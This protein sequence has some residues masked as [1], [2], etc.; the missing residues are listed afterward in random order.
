M[1]ILDMGPRIIEGLPNMIEFTVFAYDK[2]GVNLVLES[3]DQTERY[4][5][6]ETKPHV[7]QA[8]IENPAPNLL[9]SYE[10]E[11]QREYPDPYSHFQPF[12]VHGRSQVIDHSSY[13]WQ[14]SDWQG[15]NPEELIVME[16]H[17]ATFTE[18]GT[19]KA[20]AKKLDYLCH[21][22]VNALELMPVTPTP[23]RWNW[24]YDGTCLFSVN[25]NYGT[26]DDLKYL[27]DSCH[28][29]QMTVI[30]DVVYNHFGPEGTYL[31]SFGPYFTDKHHTPWGPAVNFDDNYCEYTR[32]MVLDNVFFWLD[33]YRFDGLRLDAVHALKDTSHPH[34]LQDISTVVTSLAAQTNR[35]LFVI[36]ESDQ[37][38]RMLIS[39][40]REGG[41]GID[42]QW[43]DDFHHTVHT[44]LTGEREGYYQDYGRLEDLKKV[45]QNFLYTG[46]FSTYL[47]KNR[48]TDAS[49]YPGKQ[50]VVSI[51]NHD[52]V[53][54]R[55]HGE[56]LS[57]LVEF[58]FLKLAAGM[59][60]FSPYV[61][62]LFMG[63]EY[64]EKNPFLFFTDYQDPALRKAVFAGRKD[65]FKHFSWT[66]P[67]DPQSPSSFYSSRLS[68]LSSWSEQ[69]EALFNFYRDFINLRRSHPVLASL[70]KFALNVSIAP[71]TRLVTIQRW[72]KQTS[73]IG[74]FNLTQ[75]E[76]KLEPPPSRQLINSEW[77]RY[78]GRQ[79]NPSTFLLPGQIIVY[80][81]QS[82]EP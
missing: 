7:Y 4:P 77:E 39:S 41:K 46:E 12:S 76:I 29:R 32:K 13:N 21:L 22:G 17:I 14:T 28:Q 80:E 19:F 27:I 53:G 30:L 16:I 79:P 69:N 78:K 51:Q 73:L 57:S 70:N 58:P 26:P 81:P 65:E 60:F 23:G 48:G 33:T 72:N 67:P 66:E 35:K 11:N 52:Q 1:R 47:Q 82:D 9:Y 15:K 50:F 3:S 55:A 68:P 31:S 10:L 45:Y 56:R 36:A 42:A 34:I 6:E 63:E 2:K 25:C 8:V 24:G 20:A 64:G 62:L 59:M 43:M 40:V 18:E 49:L 38:D 75:E 74:L 71:T 37:N 54:N 61:P 5:M 44:L